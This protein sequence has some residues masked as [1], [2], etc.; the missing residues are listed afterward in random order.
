MK[1][2][3]LLTDALRGVKCSPKIVFVRWNEVARV[4]IP[5]SV[6]APQR[7]GR[8][9]PKGEN[10]RGQS[11]NRLCVSREP[12]MVNIREFLAKQAA[13]SKSQNLFGACLA[14]ILHD[15]Y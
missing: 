6:Q 11:R 13:N 1:A 5:G 12:L 3:R 15:G 14:H 9:A 10:P 2:L 8:S 4:P 7:T